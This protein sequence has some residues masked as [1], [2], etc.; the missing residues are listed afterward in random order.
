MTIR[1]VAVVFGKWGKNTDFV[2]EPV[3]KECE[4][5]GN[6]CEICR[7]FLYISDV[8][9][10]AKHL[11]YLRRPCK[12]CNKMFVPTGKYQRYCENCQ[13]KAGRWGRE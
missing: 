8:K 1:K 7:T 11:Q 3:C 10:K 6:E 2:L 12:R 9:G 5:D 4:K 13:I